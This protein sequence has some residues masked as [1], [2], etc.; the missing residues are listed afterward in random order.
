VTEGAKAAFF[1]YCRDDSEFA[2]RLAEDLKTAGANVW[3]DQLDID[4]GQEWD[5][6]IEDAVRQCPQML[7]ILSPASVQSRNVR[8]EVAFALDEQK[9]IIPVLYQDCRVPLQL[10][11]IQHLDFRTDY[12]R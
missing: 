1:S 8:N 11:R 10:L 12:A 7:L 9:A 6:A 4:A 5:S 3:L 2:L